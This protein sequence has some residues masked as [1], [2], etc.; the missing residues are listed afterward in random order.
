MFY[1]YNVMEVHEFLTFGEGHIAHS[2]VAV[3]PQEALIV[4]KAESRYLR[5]GEVGGYRRPW[6][7]EE[8]LTSFV[9]GNDL[10]SAREHTIPCSVTAA[11]VQLCI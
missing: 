2:S 4:Q 3:S 1:K 11:G 6:R 8:R 5:Q 10:C 9:V 7:G